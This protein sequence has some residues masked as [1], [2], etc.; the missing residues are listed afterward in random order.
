MV[1]SE[2]YYD[3]KLSLEDAVTYLRV[4][5]HEFPFS[6]WY[7]D[8]D[9]YSLGPQSRSQAV[10]VAAMMSQF[11][12]GL[13]PRASRGLG[14]IYTSNSQRSGKTLLMKLAI[15]PVNG[16]MATQTWNSKE[17]ELRKVID[18]EMLAASR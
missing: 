11:A 15:I 6:D 9:E 1:S 14:F 10:Q 3:D 18:A 2:G 5:L 8:P 4:L 17:E 7:T 16:Q 12:R 13:V